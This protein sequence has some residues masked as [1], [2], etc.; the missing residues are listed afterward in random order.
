M[1]R[2]LMERLVMEHLLMECRLMLRLAMKLQHPWRHVGGGL[3]A[4][5][6]SWSTMFPL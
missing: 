6:G 1:E 5:L 4:N 3:S 2:L